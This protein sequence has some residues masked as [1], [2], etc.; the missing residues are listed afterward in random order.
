LPVASFFQTILA[1][2]AS[3]ALLATEIYLGFFVVARLRARPSWRDLLQLLVLA[4]TRFYLVSLPVGRGW[5]YHGGALWFAVL[6]GA[7]AAIAW[8]PR[9]EPREAGSAEE[10]LPA[11]QLVLLVVFLVLPSFVAPVAQY[12]DTSGWMDSQSYDRFAHRIA[13]GQAPAGSSEFMPLY[14]YGLA[15][16]YFLFGHFF[17]VQQIVNVLVGV[18]GIVLLALAGWNLFPSRLVLVLVVVWAALNPGFTY[19]VYFP[20][21]ES[22]YV[23]AICLAVFLWSCYWRRPRRGH[24]VLLASSAAVIVN[25][26]QQGLILALMLCLAPVVVEGIDRGER[27]RHTATALAILI[28]S[29]VPWMLRNAVVEGRASPFGMRNAAYLAILNDRRVPFYGIRYDQGFARLLE[30]YQERYPGNAEREKVMM[31]DAR[32]RLLEDPVWLGKAIFWRGVGFYGLLPPGVFAPEG[33]RPTRAD[34][35]SGFLPAA[36]PRL[37]LIGASI[38]GLA[39]CPGRTAGF[40]LALIAANLSVVLLSPTGGDPRISF[41]SLPLHILLG[42]AV[43]HSSLPRLRGRALGLSPLFGNGRRWAQLTV[44]VCAAALLCRATLGRRYAYR[45]LREPSVVWS[46]GVTLDRTRPSLND[47]LRAGSGTRE[48]SRLGQR[49]RATYIVSNEMYPP[50]FQGFVPWLPRFA[51]DPRG[52][53]YYFGYWPEGHSIGVAYTGAAV[54]AGVREGDAVEVEGVVI[55]EGSGDEAPYWVRA[56]KVRRLRT[57]GR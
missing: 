12:W 6:G 41:P 42:L 9:H 4:G 48:T 20:Q 33:P 5:R 53:T 8:T 13:T 16:F 40:L 23:P 24:L 34:E 21:I 44:A 46:P 51:S 28:L 35:W 39:A 31:R 7:V 54:E 30:E 38:L 47:D 15:G 36:M 26:R 56:E 43:F 32:H 37:L 27:V 11:T 50:K 17:F 1:L 3:G 25:I 29:L 14:Q 18:T 22:W 52:E 45:P 57:R 55:A 10:K 19:A 49:V 2:G